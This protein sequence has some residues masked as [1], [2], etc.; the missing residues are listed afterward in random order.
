M[1]IPTHATPLDVDPG[2]S[3]AADRAAWP[4]GAGAAL[5]A[6]LDADSFR[7]FDAELATPLALGFDD[8]RPYAERIAAA[9]AACGSDEAV[10]TGEGRLDGAPVAF[11]VFEFGFLGGGLGCVAGERL[12]RL[13]ER[14]VDRDLPVVVLHRSGGAR[15][16]EGTFS[17]LQMA[18]VCAA[19]ERHRAGRRP[20]VSLLGDPTMGGTLASSGALGDVVLAEP[21]ARIGFAGPRVL[22]ATV[23]LEMP[24]EVQRAETLLANGYV[25]AVVPGSALRA[26]LARLVGV[27]ARCGRPAGPSLGDEPPRALRALPDE[28]PR[29]EREALAAAWT[30][31]R[32]EAIRAARDPRRPRLDAWLG[33]LVTD[34]LE[35][36]GDRAGSDDPALRG[37]L[38]RFG[39][40]DVVVVGVDRGATVPLLRERNFGM[41]R[42]AGYRKAARLFA[43]AAKLGLPIV[44]LVDTPGADS[45]AQSEHEGQAFAIA[46]ALARLS[47]VPVP[48]VGLLFGEGGSGGA[49]ALTPVDHLVA[50]ER[51]HLSVI[52]PEG[53]AAILWR[54]RDEAARAAE[55]MRSLGPDLVDHGLADECIRESAGDARLVA[56][57]A[58]AVRRSLA[59][60]LRELTALSAEALLARR[61]ARLRADAPH[62]RAAARGA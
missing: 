35:L 45:S 26:A 55:A 18:K 13:F 32:H 10:V 37:G 27:G 42:P 34:F 50:L 11:G 25:D 59:A 62:L 52:S 60:A 17:L 39:G 46:E 3:P 38:A 16:Q 7:A 40:R 44:T 58:P 36:H 1:S 49:I 14:A 2:L 12:A 48:V 28:V 61:G 31:R 5:R 20:Y 33:A 43:L 30:G 8:G 53:C 23:R 29:E 24:D 15:M 51:T 9:R 22:R 54:T 57:A 41:P 4:A 21:R 56:E 6:L 47:R 19:I